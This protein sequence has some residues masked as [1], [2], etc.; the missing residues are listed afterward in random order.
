MIKLHLKHLLILIRKKNILSDNASNAIQK[1]KD[2]GEVEYIC[3]Y[4][5][6]KFLGLSLY[7]LSKLTM[8]NIKGN[9]DSLMFISYKYK[10][11]KLVKK[12]FQK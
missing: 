9:C 1:L 11:K 5:T 8:K 10:K 6:L 7:Q 3:V 4:Y 2:I 12:R